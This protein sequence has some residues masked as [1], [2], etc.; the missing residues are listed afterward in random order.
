MNVTVIVPRALRP[1][2]DGRREL[3]LGVPPS[4]DVGDVLQ[5][6]LTL[7]PKLSQQLPDER[8]AARQHLN[9]VYTGAARPA[10]KGAN[11][12]VQMLYLF[13]SLN[14]PPPLVRPTGKGKG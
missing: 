3:E 10:K 9:L 6:L 7:Y 12:E 2:F 13:G 11:G 14:H 5:T 4:A 1:I 8:R